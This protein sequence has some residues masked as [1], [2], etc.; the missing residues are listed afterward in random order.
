MTETKADLLK[1]QGLLTY[2][3]PLPRLIPFTEKDARDHWL[4]MIT[5]TT[6][7]Y[8]IQRRLARTERIPMVDR[9]VRWIRRVKP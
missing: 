2:S 3:P 9:V 8:A 6:P 7:S 4:S 1:R 5:P